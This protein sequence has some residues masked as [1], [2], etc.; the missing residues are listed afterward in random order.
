MFVISTEFIDFMFLDIF[1]FG[2]VYTYR[3][4]F[5]FKFSNFPILSSSCVTLC[6]CFPCFLS[7]QVQWI[8]ISFVTCTVDF[9]DR[10]GG[11]ATLTNKVKGA[12][13]KANFDFIKI[14]YP[15]N[16]G[17]KNIHLSSTPNDWNTRL[18][19]PYDGQVTLANEVNGA[20]LHMTK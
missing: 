16:L 20:R 4:K 3:F 1:C 7:R 18:N 12:R 6:F 13:G 19:S 9:V 17:H 8:K 5:K 11:Q 15:K 10:Y 14:V 2:F